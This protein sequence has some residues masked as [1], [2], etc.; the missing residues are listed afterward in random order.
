MRKRGLEDEVDLV[1]GNHFDVF[2]NREREDAFKANYEA[3]K[4]AGVD[5]EGVKWF[6]EGEMKVRGACLCSTLA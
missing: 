6:E 1:E 2:C 4:E 3:A 5:V